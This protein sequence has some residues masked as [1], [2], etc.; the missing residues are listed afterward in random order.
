MV[1]GFAGAGN[2]A[3]ALALGWQERA[4]FTDGGSGRATALAADVGG[5]AVATNRE[6]GARSDL[7]V[8][9]HKPAQLDAVA[10]EVGA[11]PLVLSLLGGV[12][13]A[14]LQDAYP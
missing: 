11:A 13:V 6:L 12:T 9:A 5:E 1:I 14:A 8:L 2:M 10:R 4:L 3:R 7:L